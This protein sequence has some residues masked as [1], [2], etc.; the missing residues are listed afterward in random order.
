[1]LHTPPNLDESV[2]IHSIFKETIDA[3][4]KTFK[5]LSK[6]S[7]DRWMSDAFLKSCVICHPQ[8]RNIYGKI[9]GG[10]VMR[11]AYEISWSVAYVFGGKKIQPV[12]MDDVAFRKPVSIGDLLFLSSQVRQ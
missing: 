4:Q 8:H 10:Y 6:S 3:S 11:K 2:L 5:R 12:F 9:F 1:M 7:K